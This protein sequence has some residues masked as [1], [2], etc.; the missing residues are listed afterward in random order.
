M[1]EPQVG[2]RLP[3]ALRVYVRGRVQLHF[4]ELAFHIPGLGKCRVRIFLGIGSLEK[5]GHGDELV[6]GL[7]REHVPEEVYRAAL[8]FRVGIDL[9]GRLQEAQVLV[10][11][12]QPNALQPA[13]L[14]AFQERTPALLA[15]AL[16]VL[17]YGHQHR[18][19]GHFAA[20]AVLWVD[21]VDKHVGVFTRERTVCTTPFF[22]T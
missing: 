12:E 3:Y 15:L 7:L 13:F 17:A 18:H 20:P 2:Q 10:R 14:E 9:R 5:D 16:A 22:Y 1:G 6:A 11:G 4:T 21:T 8:P 19:A